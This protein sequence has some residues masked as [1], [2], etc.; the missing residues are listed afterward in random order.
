MKLENQRLPSINSIKSIVTASA[1]PRLEVDVEDQSGTRDSISKL[2]GP[3]QESA[4]SMIG[5]SSPN[6][7]L[8]S[9]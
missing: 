7:H 4:P 9:R 3:T 6:L 2:Q 8:A 5:S 1:L